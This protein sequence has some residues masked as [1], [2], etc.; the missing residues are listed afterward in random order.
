MY[1]E[2]I[3]SGKKYLASFGDLSTDAVCPKRQELK[4]HL[5]LAPLSSSGLGFRDLSSR[6]YS[7]TNSLYD[8]GETILP[9]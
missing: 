8:L 5:R 3:G 2:G 4:S 7:A 6:L 9:P 1:R